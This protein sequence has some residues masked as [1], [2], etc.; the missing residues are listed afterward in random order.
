MKKIRR[1]LTTLTA[2]ACS[3]VMLGTTGLVG[4]A[5]TFYGDVD[6][7]GAINLSDLIT[8]N[9]FLAGKG[10]LQHEAAADVNAN[11]VIDAVDVEILSRFLGHIVAELPYTG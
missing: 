9:K 6:N 7:S 10:V 8:L 3:C 1:S 2:L 5:D 4:S 11:G